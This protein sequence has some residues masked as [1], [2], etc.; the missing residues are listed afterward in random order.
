[1]LDEVKNIKKINKKRQNQWSLLLVGF[2]CLAFFFLSSIFPYWQKSN[3][4][5]KFLSPDENANYVFTKLY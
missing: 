5:I 4:F 2:F 3:D 1:M